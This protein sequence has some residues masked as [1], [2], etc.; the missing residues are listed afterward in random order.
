[1]PDISDEAV[2]DI[3]QWPVER[4]AAICNALAKKPSG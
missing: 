4:V 1:M 2:A 3:F